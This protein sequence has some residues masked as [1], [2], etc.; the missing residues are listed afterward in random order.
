M[1]LLSIASAR[2]SVRIA[3]AYFVPDD[4]SLATLVEASKRGVKIEVILPGKTT[5]T[6]LTRKA[7][8]SRWGK[9][10][11]AGIAIFEYQ[12][13]MFHCKV[14]IVD[15][16]WVSVGST[17]FDSRSFRLND[18]ANLNVFESA[19]AQDQIRIF[20]VDK[21]RSRQV[22]LQEWTQRPWT[23]KVLEHAAGLLRSQL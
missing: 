12:P 23:D 19:F 5:D 22:S 2:H 8:S 21:A 9:L 16:S 13:T 14:M 20:E 11:E 1:Y 10:L 7:S 4:L 6:E 18:E 3:A 15:D 17:N